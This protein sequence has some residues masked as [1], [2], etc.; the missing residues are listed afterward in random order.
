MTDGGPKIDPAEGPRLHSQE[1]TGRKDMVPDGGA[2]RD[3]RLFPNE[4]RFV[5]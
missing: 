1:P 4:A 2:P 3:G 5:L